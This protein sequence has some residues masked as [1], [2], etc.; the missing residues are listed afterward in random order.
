MACG[1]P[2]ITSNY[3]SMKEVSGGAA[4]LVNPTST[5]SIANAMEKIIG[6]LKL[7]NTII[8]K[9]LDRAKDFSWLGYARKIVELYNKI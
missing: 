2:V 8:T 7:R 6:D 3:G 4:I 9:G 5:K 1:C